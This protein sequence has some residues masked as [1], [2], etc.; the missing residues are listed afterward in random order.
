MPSHR[1]ERTTELSYCTV[2][3]SA[4]EGIDRAKE[5]VKGLKSAGGFIRRELGHRLRLRHVPELIF[6]ATDSIE[7]SANISRILSSLDIP[8]DEEESD[9]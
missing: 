4:M 1:I 8:S 5:A 3:V 2:Q 7:Y 9:E 6:N